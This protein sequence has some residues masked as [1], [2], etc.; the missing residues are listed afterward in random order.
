MRR[1]QGG[2]IMYVARFSYD[3]LP[4]N[5]QNALDFILGT[6]QAAQQ[7]RLTARI[8]V[9]LTRGQGGGAALQF[10][11]ELANLDQLDQFRNRGVGSSEDTGHWM[12]DFSKILTAPPCVEIL[13][14]EEQRSVAAH[15]ASSAADVL[16][17]SRRPRNNGK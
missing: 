4:V 16:D 6:M 2:L 15:G 17:A 8:L 12:H 11:V 10:E 5:R 1:H 9:P 14:A 3:V 13:R 7:S